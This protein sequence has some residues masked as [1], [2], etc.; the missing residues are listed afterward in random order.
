MKCKKILYYLILIFFSFYIFSTPYFSNREPFNILVYGIF[1]FLSFF[2]IAYRFLYFKSKRINFRIF[3]LPSFAL[4]SSIGTIFFSHEFRYFLTVVLLS[5]SFVVL[6][7]M[8]EEINNVR[9]ILKLTIYSLLIFVF[10]FV[11][12]YRKEIFDF[13]NLGNNRLAVD[14]YFDNVNAIAYYFAGCCIL[15]LYCALYFK[16]KIELIYLLPFAICFFLGVLTA[17]RAFLIGVTCASLV[18]FVV[19]FFKKPYILIPGLV[20]LTIAIVLLFTLPAFENLKKRIIDMFNMI[21]G[22]AYSTD[23]STATRILWQEYAAYLGSKRMFIGNGLNGFAVFSGTG[24]YSHA[25]FAELLCDVG[26]IG[27]LLYYSVFFVSFYDLVKKKFEFAP[28]TATLLVF[29]IVREFLS[30]AYTSKFNAFIFA[31]IIYAGSTGVYRVKKEVKM[32][33]SAYYCAIEI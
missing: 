3:L 24:T 27:L 30:V 16:K 4:F 33:N 8:F 23:Y 26:L 13:K 1:A 31:L 28:L 14:N 11:L 17:S 22:S 2:V 9:L 12:H 29:L 32:N 19:K 5:L 10:L 6:Y 25:N 15:C 21:T 7:F 18:I 20:I